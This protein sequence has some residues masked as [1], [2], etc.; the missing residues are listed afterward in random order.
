MA[1]P[2]PIVVQ[3]I[4][5]ARKRF[6][7]SCPLYSPKCFPESGRLNCLGDNDPESYERAT[8]RPAFNIVDVMKAAGLRVKQIGL[9][10]FG[11]IT[12]AEATVKS[13]L[14]KELYASYRNT[15]YAG[16]AFV[17]RNFYGIDP[18][19]NP[20]PKELLPVLIDDAKREVR[21]WLADMELQAMALEKDIPQA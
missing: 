6:C 2:P 8:G 20:A 3:L 17:L 5:E 19:D 11:W 21:E 16:I 4:A 9:V 1:K 18:D 12:F 13:E 15:F 10:E 7:Q 14:D